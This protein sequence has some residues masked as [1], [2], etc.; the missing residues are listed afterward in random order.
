MLFPTQCS[1]NNL[2]QKW[3]GRVF[4][5]LFKV[6]RLIKEYA[7]LS[8]NYSLHWSDWYL[9]RTLSQTSPNNR[10]AFIFA[11]GLCC[12]MVGSALKSRSTCSFI[13]LGTLQG[14][15]WQPRTKELTR[16]LLHPAAHAH[17][18]SWYKPWS[19]SNIWSECTHR[20]LNNRT[21]HVCK[22][23]LY[24]GDKIVD[25]EKQTG[26]KNPKSSCSPLQLSKPTHT[27]PLQSREVP[28]DIVLASHF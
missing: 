4:V 13:Q 26:K 12:L 25:S 18:L 10:V 11:A 15:Q 1:G 28:C 6:G 27:A 5:C 8:S 19:G 20:N 2:F 3:I 24:P 9:R 21:Y 16:T 17:F 7:F 22:R 23:P 14:T